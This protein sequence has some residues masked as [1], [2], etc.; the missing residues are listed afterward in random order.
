MAERKGID[1]S[2]ISSMRSTVGELSL[3]IGRLERCKEIAMRPLTWS[4]VQAPVQY[5][6]EKNFSGLMRAVRSID[7]AAEIILRR[8]K[9]MNEEKTSVRKRSGRRPSAG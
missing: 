1:A 3:A 4:S 8:E 7:E 9:A 2:F 5:D 6:Y